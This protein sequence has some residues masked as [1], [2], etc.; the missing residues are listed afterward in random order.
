MVP[1]TSAK[2][3]ML[4]AMALPTSIHLS[5]T[6]ESCWKASIGVRVPPAADCVNVRD[7]DDLDGEG[8]DDDG[9]HCLHS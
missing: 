9:H 2:P 5:T 7:D 3:R 4:E 8:D 1:R 6:A